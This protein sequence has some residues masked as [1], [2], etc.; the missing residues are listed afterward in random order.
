MALDIYL[1]N[2]QPKLADYELY[3][4][5]QKDP[6]LEEKVQVLSKE[7]KKQG[8]LRKYIPEAI[9]RYKDKKLARL[10][11]NN[12]KALEAASLMAD[13]NVHYSPNMS[14]RKARKLYRRIARREMAKNG[15]GVLVN[16][17]LIALFWTPIFM[18]LQGTT[19]V[20]GA[21]ALQNMRNFKNIWKGRKNVKYVKNSQVEVL[22]QVLVDKCP[23][24]KLNNP[25]LEE[26]Y[27]AYLTRQAIAE[28]NMRKAIAM[29]RKEAPSMLT[30]VRY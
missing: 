20:F 6:D 24:D 13:V 4:K 26:F 8:F 18:W 17:G 15:I 5:S 2:V 19:I 30:Y 23:T 3:H 12:I 16:S 28:E 14:K 10:Q 7:V 1:V 27:V 29:A 11:N 9:H 21:L 22:G 25:A